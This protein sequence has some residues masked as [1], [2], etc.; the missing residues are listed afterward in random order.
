MSGHIV[1]L[2]TPT[3]DEF[4]AKKDVFD[5][6]KENFSSKKEVFFLFPPQKRMLNS[7]RER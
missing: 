5:S 6:K 4:Y 3:K 2:Q 1:F 7:Q